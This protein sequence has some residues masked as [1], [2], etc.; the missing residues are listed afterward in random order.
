MPEISYLVY[1][2]PWSVLEIWVAESTRNTAAWAARN[3]QDYACSNNGQL[4]RSLV[5]QR[6]CFRILGDICRGGSEKNSGYLR[7]S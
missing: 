3:W 4:S 1:E 2:V 5:F 6:I 7:Q